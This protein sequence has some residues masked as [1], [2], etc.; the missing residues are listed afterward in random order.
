MD[1]K[2]QE[3]TEKIYREGVEK[4]NEEAGRIIAEA[5]EQKRSI[6]HDA[7]VEAE[8][9]LASAAKQVAA[10]KKS[11]ESELKLFAAQFVEDLRNELTDLIAGKIVNVNIQPLAQDPAFMQQV[12]LAIVK[13]W[14]G[15]EGMTIQSAA[16]E[17]LHQYIE[18]NAKELL[19]SGKVKLEKVNGK[20]A[21][22]TIV[23]A[24]GTYKVVFGEDELLAFFKEYLRPQIVAMLF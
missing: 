14:A 9:M 20:P 7:T 6:L 2:I 24:D 8:Q 15:T 23:P 10:L 5:Q 13:E 19:D 22:F 12:V 16:A 11:A 3:L 1:V 18:S 21:S 17:R 4:G